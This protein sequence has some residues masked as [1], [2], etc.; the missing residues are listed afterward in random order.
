MKKKIIVGGVFLILISIA[1]IYFISPSDPSK[2]IYKTLNNPAKEQLLSNSNEDTETMNIDYAGIYIIMT[3]KDEQNKILPEDTDIP[4]LNAKVTGVYIKKKQ[5]FDIPSGVSVRFIP[6]TFDHLGKNENFILDSLGQYYIG[7]EIYPGNYRV[8]LT[9]KP[10]NTTEN[11]ELQVQLITSGK[12]ETNILLDKNNNQETIQLNLGE[13]LR[14]KSSS[15][16]II[17]N[18]EKV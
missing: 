13:F 9:E 1:I 3:E 16:D 8:T 15:F 5:A 6:I 7:G 4:P 11:D 17:L 10:S 14:V 12:K 2:N 18:F